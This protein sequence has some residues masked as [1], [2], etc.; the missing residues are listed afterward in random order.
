[1]LFTFHVA[2]D[3]RMTLSRMGLVAMY[4]AWGVGRGAWGVGRGGH[5]ES[6]DRQGRAMTS[7]G[8][9]KINQMGG[10]YLFWV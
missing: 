10:I 5:N 7:G 1:M 6:I 2:L 8:A 3:R 4:V 9:W